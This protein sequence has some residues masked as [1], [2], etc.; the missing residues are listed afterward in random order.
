MTPNAD[1]QAPAVIDRDSPFD[2]AAALRRTEGDEELLAEMARIFLS[3]CPRLISQLRTAVSHGDPTAIEH[4][5][6]EIKGCVGNF[7][8]GQAFA[9][10]ARLEGLGCANQMADVGEAARLLEAELERLTQAL[11]RL[12]A[13]PD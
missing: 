3:D 11:G 7:A 8:A 6:H 5:A 12:I 2:R 13:L 4:G 10:A 1:A 9:A